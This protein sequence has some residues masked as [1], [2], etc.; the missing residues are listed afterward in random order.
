[1]CNL[2]NQEMTQEEL[3]LLGPVIRDTINWPDAADI[4][5]DLPSPIIRQG[6]DGV[7]EL[8][9]ARWGMPKSEETQM[10]A[11]EK[12]AAKLEAK[13]K[14]YD[15]AEL[16]RVEPNSGVTNIRRTFIEHW[17][18]WLQP[19]QHRCLV[20]FT[21]FAENTDADR[22]RLAWF[23][24]SEDKPVAFFAGI[25]TRWTGIRKIKEGEVTID[26]FGFLT[27][28]PNEIVKPYHKKAMPVILTN[29]EEREQ[30]MTAPWKEAKALQR[31]LRDD[32]L[33]VV[34]RPAKAAQ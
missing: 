14:P 18:T 2:F 4:Y 19:I 15:I 12:R 9:L 10:E 24:L 7:R 6:A 1:M 11:V 8:V 30:W 25:W 16:L 17:Q 33:V 31:P 26:I 5:P 29:K 3:R 28:R 22:S 27:T 13:G 20:P 21:A 34:Q 32:Q 23:A